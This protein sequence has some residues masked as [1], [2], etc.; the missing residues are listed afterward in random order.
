M[1]ANVDSEK[2]I[3]F[4]ID[5]LRTLFLVRQ[6]WSDVKITTIQNCFKKSGMFE[7]N[8]EFADNDNCLI[9]EELWQ[10]AKD[11]VYIH[12]TIDEYLDVDD[13]LESIDVPEDEDDIFKGNLTT[14]NDFVEF[15]GDDE[16][17][18]E[19]DTNS[20]V[21]ATPSQ[22]MCYFDQIQKFLINQE[23]VPNTLFEK[24]TDVQK[25]VTNVICSNQGRKQS[26]ITNYFSSGEL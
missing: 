17:E 14:E 11:N 12:V 13:Y 21:L 3:D 7:T 22:I 10:L 16:E 2:P 23:N 15:I 6:A 18:E 20:D 8:L 24:I 19:E 26:Q 25:E 5:I 1:I 4:K 9:D